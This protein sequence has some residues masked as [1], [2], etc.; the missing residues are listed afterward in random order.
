VALSVFGRPLRNWI[1]PGFDESPLTRG[2]WYVILPV[3]AMILVMVVLALIYRAARPVPTSWSSVL[4]GAAVATILWWCANLL[5]GI[6]VRKMKYGLLF[7][8][9]AAAVGLMV[10]MELSAMIV[11]LGAAWNAE[12]PAPP[13]NDRSETGSASS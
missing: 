4:P 1:T 8:G 7:G 9:L 10:W 12:N 2:L 11:F 13:A 3:L 5:F 6:Y